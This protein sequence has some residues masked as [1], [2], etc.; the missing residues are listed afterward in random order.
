MRIGFIGLGIM[1]KPMAGHLKAAGHDIIVPERASL[2]AEE[3][4]GYTVVADPKAVAAAPQPAKQRSANAAAKPD[5]ADEASRAEGPPQLR[6]AFSAP[7]A[8]NGAVLTGA[9]PVVPAG[10]FDSRWSGA[11]SR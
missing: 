3:R 6:T 2:G 7:P 5:A 4:A 1:G 10:T 11:G 8:S 9:Q